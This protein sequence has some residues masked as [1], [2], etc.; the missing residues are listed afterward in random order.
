[1][2]AVAEEEKVSLVGFGSLPQR[3]NVVEFVN[4]DS[5]AAGISPLN[6]ESMAI[7][8]GRMMIERLELLLSSNVDFGFETTL[9]SRTFAPF[10][11]RC[12]ERGYAVQLL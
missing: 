9:A 7:A 4:A 8:A 6:P 1:M 11:R 3:W 5:I 10:L 2:A 12:K